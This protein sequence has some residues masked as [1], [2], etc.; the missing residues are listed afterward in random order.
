VTGLN[1]N[2]TPDTI[3][4]SDQGGALSVK[5][6]PFEVPSVVYWIRE[7]VY[8]RVYNVLDWK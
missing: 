4:L 6:E 7:I 5:A 2:V 1:L 3:I 8:E